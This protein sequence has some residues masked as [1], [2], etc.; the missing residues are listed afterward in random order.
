MSSNYVTL[1]DFRAGRVMLNE[2][3]LNSLRNVIGRSIRADWKK[4]RIENLTLVTLLK[5][6]PHWSF[7]R[8]IF[9][10]DGRCEYVAGQDYDSEIKEV[11]TAI[12]G[13]R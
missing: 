1:D 9:Y 11:Q 13:K 2:G 6:P 8:I 4:I 12:I 10:P 7:R 3:H 5:V